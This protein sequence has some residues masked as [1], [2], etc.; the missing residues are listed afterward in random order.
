[1]VHP[2]ANGG[3]KATLK[4]RFEVGGTQTAAEIDGSEER[5]VT[6]PTRGDAMKMT[7]QAYLTGFVLPN[8]FFHVSIAYALLRHNGVEIGKRDYLGTP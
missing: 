5:E 7:G 2:A 1:M 3:N 4:Q 6:V 8:L